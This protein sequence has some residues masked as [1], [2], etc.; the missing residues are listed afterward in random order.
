MKIANKLSHLSGEEYLLVHEAPLLNEIVKEIGKAASFNCLVDSLADNG[1]IVVRPRYAQ[2][3]RIG[4]SVCSQAD[5]LDTF[6]F[7]LRK[8][9]MDEIDVGIEIL[10]MKSMAVEMSSGVPYYEGELYNVVRQGRGVPAVP[11]VLLGIDV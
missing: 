6:A 5:S 2:K 4:I 9:V 3:H 11:L 10:P 1:W 8:Y 7:H